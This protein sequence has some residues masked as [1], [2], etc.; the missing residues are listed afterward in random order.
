MASWLTAPFSRPLGVSIIHFQGWLYSFTINRRIQGRPSWSNRRFRGCQCEPTLVSQLIDPFPQS[1]YLSFS[2][3]FS[4][5]GSFFLLF[6]CSLFP[7]LS[8][9]LGCFPPPNA[10]EAKGIQESYAGY[11]GELTY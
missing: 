1:N 10:N 7:A 3:I 11:Y 5:Y 6:R 9:S 8:F 4:V 2:G